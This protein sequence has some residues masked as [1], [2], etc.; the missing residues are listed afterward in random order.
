MHIG[1]DKQSRPDLGLDQLKFKETCIGNRRLQTTVD[2]CG[3]DD[4]SATVVPQCLHIPI[5]HVEL[6]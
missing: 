2:E 5:T 4:A 3:S 6:C 1:M